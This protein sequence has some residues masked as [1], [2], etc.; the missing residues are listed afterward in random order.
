MND[1]HVVA[2][3]YRITHSDR[4]NF[5]EAEPLE[6]ETSQFIVRVEKGT[7]RFT[8]KADYSNVTEARAAIEPFVDMWE[9][10]DA[11]NPELSGFRLVYSTSEIIDRNRPPGNYGRL[12]LPAI[13]MSAVGVQ[14]FGYRLYPEPPTEQAAMNAEVQVMAY[15]HWLYRHGR[16]SLAAMAYF[17][18]TVLEISTERERDRRKHAAQRY[19]INP[20]VLGTIAKLTSSKGGRDARKGRGIARDFT[21]SERRWIELTIK[22]LI[23]RAAEVA[24][25]PNHKFPTVKMA[26]L[27]SL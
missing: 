10:W 26:N 7:A 17:C 12:L 1:P 2:L 9:M 23:R 15:R 4:V 22:K 8:L 11:L 14:N 16:D 27:S 3:I 25:D 6:F 18:L 21:P 5:D 19:N 13:R 20:S 24:E